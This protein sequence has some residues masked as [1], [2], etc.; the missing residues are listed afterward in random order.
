VQGGPARRTAGHAGQRRRV[1][2]G[3]L[4]V[5]PPEDKPWGERETTLTHPD[6]HVIRVRATR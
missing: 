6:G 2:A 4:V 3:L 1:A 5:S